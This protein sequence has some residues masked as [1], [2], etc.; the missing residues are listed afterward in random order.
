M[1]GEGRVS[2]G[3]LKQQCGTSDGVTA[4]LERSSEFRKGRRLVGLP[5]CLRPS[6]MVAAMSLPSILFIPDRFGDYRLWSDIPDRLQGRAQAIH[7]DQ[8]DVPWMSVNGEFLEKARQLAPDGSFHIV[9][10]HGGA[11]RFAFALAEAGLAKGPGRTRPC[12]G[13]RQAD[14]RQ[15]IGHGAHDLKS[16]RPTDDRLRNLKIR[17][18]PAPAVRADSCA[19]SRT[20][21][22][23]LLLRRQ[24]R[25]RP[26][27]ALRRPKW[28]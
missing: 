5:T 10:A 4:P 15:A 19:P 1:A 24:T 17:R 26:D 20:R 18:S 21:T 27:D 11:A 6:V 8:H 23:G 28:L 22:T 9:A 13:R 16:R 14:R 3:L 2:R 7:F 12:C 25:T